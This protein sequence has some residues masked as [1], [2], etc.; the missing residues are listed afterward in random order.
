MYGATQ[1]IPIPKEIVPNK[2][3]PINVRLN[4]TRFPRLCVIRSLLLFTTSSSDKFGSSA[5]ITG[6]SA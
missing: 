3:Q 6:A 2:I 5:V 4:T 1:S